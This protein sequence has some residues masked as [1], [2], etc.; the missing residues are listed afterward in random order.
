MKRRHLDGL[1][2]IEL[3]PG[4][5]IRTSQDG[6][7]PHWA[8]II[9]ESFTNDTFDASS[10]ESVMKTHPAYQPDRIFFAC[11]P[12]GVPCGTA[13]AYRGEAYGADTGYVHY[14]GV[15]PAQVGKKLGAALSL[16]VLHKFRAEGLQSAVL[17][18]DDFRL[19]A[20]KT[21]LRLGFSPM[22]VHENQPARWARVFERTGLSAPA[23]YGV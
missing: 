5:T 12:D 11:G 8:R 18:T 2:G 20:I 4:Y 1:P 22:I 21:Y 9:R 19:P 3:P 10:F 17:Q 13:S 15:C 16:A 6:D 14:V 7:G 23:D